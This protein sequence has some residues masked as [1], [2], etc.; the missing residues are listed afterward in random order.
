MNGLLVDLFAGAG[1]ASVG[2]ESALE[3]SVD[4]AVN[5][6]ATAIAVHE[7]NHPRTL[8]FATDI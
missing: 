7:A 8:H 5:H 3:R 1:G 2:I 6:D 4:L